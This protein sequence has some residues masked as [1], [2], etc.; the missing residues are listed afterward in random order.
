[1]TT[2]RINQITTIKI[3]AFPPEG[4]SRPILNNR[5]KR[6]I[7]IQIFPEGRLLFRTKQSQI[8]SPILLVVPSHFSSHLE[9]SV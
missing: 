8:L 1:M 3:K 9:S 2:G 4:W 5:N 6:F 7:P